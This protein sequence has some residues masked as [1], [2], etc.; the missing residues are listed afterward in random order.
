MHRDSPVPRVQQP[1]G[2]KD[3]DEPR[4]G[5]SSHARIGLGRTAVLEAVIGA[6][7]AAT[8]ASPQS[9]WLV[10]RARAAGTLAQGH[11]RVLVVESSGRLSHVDFPSL[12]EAETYATD[13]ASEIDD[14]TPAAF[15]FDSAFDV[16]AAGR[17]R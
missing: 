9:E 8:A 16:V 3:A 12:A 7:R 17:Q 13:A 10:E 11:H 5:V 2:T 4:P 1:Q 14:P 15:V 6:D